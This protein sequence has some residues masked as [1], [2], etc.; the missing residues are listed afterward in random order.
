MKKNSKI[1][2]KITSV[3]LVLMI[4]VL[5][6]SI[7]FR[8]EILRAGFHPYF[9]LFEAVILFLGFLC[10]ILYFILKRR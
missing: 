6:V 5:F 2:S 4:L 10:V 7:V 1:L 9:M 8:D 3:I